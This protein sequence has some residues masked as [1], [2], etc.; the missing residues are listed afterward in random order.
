MS[1]SGLTGERKMP[2][3]SKRKVL[4]G[5]VVSD[6]MDK[7]VI[8]QVGRVFH[9][10]VYRKVMRRSCRFAAHNAENQARAG[11][12]VQIA[13]TRP[14]SAAKRWRVVSVLQKAR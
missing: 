4:E 14:L 12:L 2:D 10:P 3:R 1:L 9:H 11:D 13:E 8:V 5:T 6:K 7:T